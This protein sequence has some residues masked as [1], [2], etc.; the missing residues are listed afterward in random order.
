MKKMSQA[1]TTTTKKPKNSFFLSNEI[2]FNFKIKFDFF[3][4]FGK[5]IQF[6][7]N[8]KVIVNYT[9]ILLK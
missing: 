2:N 6:K 5:K 7:L 1:H 3:G 9:K 8:I 4:N